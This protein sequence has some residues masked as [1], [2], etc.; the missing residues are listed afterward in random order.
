MGRALEVAKVNKRLIIRDAAT[1]AIVYCAPSFL[2]PVRDRSVMCDLA[3]RLQSGDG[4]RAI[5]DFETAHSPRT[6]KAGSA[7]ED[8]AG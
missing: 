3:E 4:I 8:T 6:K 1:M 7:R 5:M 2:R